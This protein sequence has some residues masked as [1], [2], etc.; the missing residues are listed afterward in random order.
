MLFLQLLVDGLVSGSAMGVVA[1]TFT[2]IYTTTQVF[3]IAHGSIYT[4]G[5]Y[6]AWCLTEQGVP[7][8]LA[9]PVA[10]L[11]CAAMGALVQQQLYNRLLQ[12]NATPLVLLIGS[13]G[14]ALVLENTLAAV[15]SPNILNFTSD[16]ATL[17]V[18]LAGVTLS[19]S[20]LA[21]L[22]SGS[23]AVRRHAGVGGIIPRLAGAPARS[24]PTTSW[25]KSPA[26]SRAA[27]ISSCSR[28]PPGWLPFPAAWLRWTMGCIPTAA[29]SSC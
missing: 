13:L 27:C 20:Q 14:A 2:V 10:M 3:H 16:W 25:R 22:F 1:V 6:V 17:T 23:T 5:G 18:R 4:L 26:S 24:Q 19:L 29:R 7:F 8:V 9:L 12:R 21:I 28:S 11:C 15:F